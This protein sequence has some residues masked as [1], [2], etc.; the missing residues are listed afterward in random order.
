MKPRSGEQGQGY[1]SL[2]FVVVL[3][4]HRLAVATYVSTKRDYA[5]TVYI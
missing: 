1:I 3:P 5:P 4:K 2:S